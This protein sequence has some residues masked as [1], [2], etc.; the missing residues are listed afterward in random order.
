MLTEA[1]PFVKWAGGKRQLLNELTKGLPTFRNYHEPFIG[2]GA[3]FF[4]LE[5]EN[6]L[7]QAFLSDFN[8]ELINTYRVI[9]SDV[10]GLM[11]ELATPAYANNSLAFYKIRA[12]NPDSKVKRAARFIYLNKTA[13]NGLYRVNSK[14]GF[15]VPFGKYANPNILDGE[16]LMLVH[17]ALQKDELYCGDFTVV[18]KNA[19]K[20]DL[21]Y[22]DPPYAPI[23]KTANFTSYTKKNFVE[24]DQERLLN[25]FKELDTRGC[26]V[27]LSNSYSDYTSDLYAEFEPETVFASRAIN[28]KGDRRGK[29]KELIVRNWEPKVAQRK[30][31]EVIPAK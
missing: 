7:K 28:C 17:R 22:F 1:K 13:F 18:L 6:R 14:G 21:V 25:V 2:G 19:R 5:A 16:N 27:M 11:S 26:F 8:E 31:V 24:N 4:R 3:L 15:N 23:S 12:S 10:F 20:G 30:L 29:I 9:K